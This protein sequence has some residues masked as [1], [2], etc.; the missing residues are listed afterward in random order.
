MKAAQ[1]N[2]YGGSEVI[3]INEIPKPQIKEG[4]V[5]V[6]VIAASLNPIDYKIRLGY[7]KDAIKSLPITLGTDFAGKIVEVADGVNE[8]K[9]GDEVY[10]NAIVLGG[11][12]G[13]LAEFVAANI[14]ATALKPKTLDFITSGALPLAAA[15]A[16]QAIEEHIQIKAGQKILIQGG[17]GGIGS[18]AIQL[19]KMHGAYV[20]ATTSSETL[21]FVK[22]LGVDEVIDYKSQDFTQVIKDYD[23]VFD[24]TGS[25][26]AQKSL[27]VLKK[28]GVIVSMTAQFDEAEVSRYGVIAITQNTKST[29]D[30]F[31]RIAQ[32]IDEGKLKPEVDKVFPLEQV[33][34]AFDYS[35]KDHPRGKVIIAIKNN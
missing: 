15:S 25:D 8:F 35:E 17:G 34:E 11:G 13:T 7:L 20:A 12:S 14:T 28:G 18:L 4:Q 9:V 5:L 32:L 24:T 16:L 33:K 22:S 30:K 19:A 1:I 21:D 26:V 3:E 29:A 23:A 6:Q 10:G 27:T 2:Q 31:R